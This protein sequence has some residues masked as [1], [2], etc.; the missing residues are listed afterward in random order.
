MLTDAGEKITLSLSLLFAINVFLLLVFKILPATGKQVPLISKYLI[1]TS[2]MNITSILLTV[3]NNNISFRTPLTHRMPKWLRSF[4]VLYLPK[5]LLMRTPQH[6]T[7]EP[8]FTQDTCTCKTHSFNGNGNVSVKRRN[9]HDAI[10][11][12]FAPEKCHQDKQPVSHTLWTGDC[13]TQ[14]RCSSEDCKCIELAQSIEN[15]IYMAEYRRAVEED[16][17]VNAP[18]TCHQQS[19]FRKRIFSK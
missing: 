1:F 17:Q 14:C 12:D 5:Y 6:S 11:D 8:F 3:M 10:S 4:F 15:I 7:I 2:A 13:P 19:I 18:E 9:V 16:K